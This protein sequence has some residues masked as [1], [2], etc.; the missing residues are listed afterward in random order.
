MSYAKKI[1]TAT[2]LQG[3]SFTVSVGKETEEIWESNEKGIFEVTN[4]DNLVVLS[5]DCIK[6]GD[7]LSLT[8][9]IGKTD[10]IAWLGAYRL[11]S[12]QVDDNNIEIKVPIADFDIEYETTKAS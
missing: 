12:Y 1:G 2:L 8:A 7:S 3:T 10:T 6:S 5:G 4:E 11:L 9:I